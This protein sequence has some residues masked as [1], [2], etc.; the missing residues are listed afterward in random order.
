MFS[1]CNYLF[2]FLYISFTC[3]YLVQFLKYHHSC[4]C[5]YFVHPM[6]FS[7]NLHFYPPVTSFD[8]YIW[9]F[10]SLATSLVDL[11]ILYFVCQM[12]CSCSILYA[13][14]CWK[15]I[16]FTDVDPQSITYNPFTLVPLETLIGT[17]PLAIA[18]LLYMVCIF[19]YTIVHKLSLV[20][21]QI[22]L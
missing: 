22:Y 15:V 13:L 14:R 7:L 4:L 19:W 3:A 9:Y 16:S 21:A 17:L 10:L 6:L 1:R 12:L 20:K 18:Y 11:C 8:T 5:M 2:C